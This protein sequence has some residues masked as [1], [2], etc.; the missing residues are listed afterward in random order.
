MIIFT[1]IK[2][3][4]SSIWQHK[5]RSFLTMLG[6]IIGVS[7]VI[8]LI[9]TGQGVKRDIERQI[10]DLGSNLLFVIPG[11]IN[12][13]QTGQQV[14]PSQML[15]GT[16]LTEKDLETVKSI[17]G[18]E[19]MA[20]IMIVSGILKYNDKVSPRAILIGTTKDMKGSTNFQ[21]EQG[22]FLQDEDEN[23]DVI[24]LGKVPAEELFGQ[25]EAVGK[26]IL[27][28]KRE[29]EVIGTFSKP[30]TSNI[31]GGEEF[32]SFVT[33]PFSTA[34]D[35]AGSVQIHRILIKVSQDKDIKEM[36][37]IVREKILANHAGE[38]DFSVLTQEDLLNLLGM[39][40]NL[41]TLLITSIA[42]ISLIVG[43]IGIMNIMLVSV[44]ERTREIGLRKAVGATSLAILWQFLIEAVILSL[45]GG[46]IGIIFSFVETWIVAAKTAITPEVTLSSILLA[47]GVCIGVGIIFGL[48]PAIRAARK[49][50]IEALRYE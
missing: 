1:L 26:K 20:P 33:I 45:L 21:T 36:A 31:L 48:A 8:S 40:L 19:K 29:F 43:G 5:A 4:F 41:M 17:N 37:K 22:R 47:A 15:G 12:P 11:K 50:P 32:Q 27:I 16:A 35:I 2:Q 38:E 30:G 6:V 7:A 14:S 49:D 13:A 34:K 39:V 23:K 44:T 9:A 25:E 24:A 18:V 10:T 28:G 3:A 42:S 46:A